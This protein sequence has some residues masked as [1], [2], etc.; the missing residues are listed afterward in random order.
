M[1]ARKYRPALYELVNKGPLKPDK[2]GSLRAPGWFFDKR[3]KEAVGQAAGSTGSTV[4]LRPQ[5]AAN[6]EPPQSGQAQQAGTPKPKVMA[7]MTAAP[8][9]LAAAPAVQQTAKPAKEPVE[10]ATAGQERPFA[11]ETDHGRVKVGIPYWAA[12]LV[13]LGLVFSLLVAYR[14]GRSGDGGP[15]AEPVSVTDEEPA[16][17]QSR[18]ELSEVRQSAPRPEIL[19]LARPTEQQP[20][21]EMTTPGPA[22][23][24]A[25]ATGSPVAPTRP[26]ETRVAAATGTYVLVMCGSSDRRDL[27]PVQEYFSKQGLLTLIGRTGSR[28]VL[29][30]AAGVES[31]RSAEAGKLKQLVERYGARYNDEKPASAPSFT[32]KTFETAFWMRRDAL[33]LSE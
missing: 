30:S 4:P 27:L 7:P 15:S 25:E 24:D 29:H 31:T 10:Q 23:A 9:R 6:G 1:S 11:L 2:Q 28:Y 18:Q 17:E 19:G 8:P 16:A 5:T 3:G 12:G 22:R 33:A 32:A 13:V 21:P 26:S 14:I 20:G